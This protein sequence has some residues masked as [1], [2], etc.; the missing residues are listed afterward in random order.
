MLIS[1]KQQEANRQNAQHST[2]PVT[3]EGK[4]RVSLN[5][6]TFGLRTH[7]TIVHALAEDATEYLRL[8]DDFD[9]EWKPWD[10][11]NCAISKPWSAPNGCWRAPPTAKPKSMKKPTAASSNLPCSPR[12]IKYG[13]N[14]SAPSAP[15]WKI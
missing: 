3:P 15:P 12:S 6:F 11:P 13:R 1:K 9:L 5:A 4:A 7:Q 10:A 2:G 8:W 14:S